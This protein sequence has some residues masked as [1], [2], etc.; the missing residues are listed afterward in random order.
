MFCDFFS[1]PSEIAASGSTNDSVLRP[2]SSS[3]IFFEFI[4]NYVVIKDPYY[5]RH[6][7]EPDRRVLVPYIWIIYCNFTDLIISFKFNCPI[8]RHE[9]C[10]C[11]GRVYAVVNDKI[12]CI[13]QAL[14]AEQLCTY[15]VIESVIKAY[16]QRWECPFYV[17]NGSYNVAVVCRR[18][19]I[20]TNP[21]VRESQFRACWRRVP[22]YRDRLLHY[23]F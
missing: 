13:H 12:N 5:L 18:I 9:V 20:K 23:F 7:R 8:E 1:H 6:V 2:S 11:R 16:R 14:L 10:D 22:Q 19:S 3:F 4:F 21:A 17:C 15:P